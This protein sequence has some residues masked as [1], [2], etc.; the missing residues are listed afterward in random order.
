MHSIMLGQADDDLLEGLP[1][2]AALFA[3]GVVFIVLGGI[4]DVAG[5]PVEAALAGAFALIII[6]I[7]VF[8]HVL[9]LALGRLD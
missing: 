6:A 7:A 5:L 4:L 2:S 1:K 3:F 8:S 9:F